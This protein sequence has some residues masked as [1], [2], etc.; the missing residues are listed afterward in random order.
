MTSQRPPK[1]TPH[2]F[3]SQVLIQS[4]ALRATVV[5]L[6]FINLLSSMQKVTCDMQGLESSERRLQ[7]ADALLPVIAKMSPSMSS[8]RTTLW[9]LETWLLDARQGLM[10]TAKTT[11]AP[12]WTGDAAA[13]EA[14]Y[15]LS[16]TQPSKTL[17]RVV[18]S[19]VILLLTERGQ[20]VRILFWIAHLRLFLRAHPWVCVA[21]RRLTRNLTTHGLV[22]ATSQPPCTLCPAAQA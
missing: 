4:S 3:L 11:W 6:S 20:H 12:D 21:Q 2:V 1:I 15:H 14:S 9:Q 22:P 8:H 7:R 17:R 16:S 13:F 18:H 19:L 5:L 10:R